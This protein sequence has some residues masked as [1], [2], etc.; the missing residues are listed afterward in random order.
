MKLPAGSLERTLAILRKEWLD[1]LRDRRTATVTLVSSIAA[2]P[3]FLMLIFNLIA[4]QAERAR[5]LAL[6]VAGAEYAP[7]LVAFLER[8]Q[9]NITPRRRPIT[10]RRSAAVI[11]TS[12]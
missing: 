1:M 4:S 8:Q 10:T 3:I 5:D 6:P 2:G 12:C 9:V 11:S 7:A